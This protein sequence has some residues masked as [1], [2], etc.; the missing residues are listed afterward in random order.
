MIRSGF[1]SLLLIVI[2]FAPVVSGGEE[3]VRLSISEEALKARV[4]TLWYGI[5]FAK[6]GGGPLNQKCGYVREDFL[7]RGEGEARGWVCR[8]EGLLKIEAMGQK[9]EMKLSEEIVFGGSAPYPFREAR[10]VQSTGPNTKS[11]RIS[12]KG[13]GFEAVVD[14]GGEKQVLEIPRIDFTLADQLAGE[15]WVRQ[16][17]KPGDVLRTRDFSV[18]DLE[19][20]IDTHK[21][22]EVKPSIVAGVKMDVYVIRE[23]SQKTGD[24]GTVRADPK[25]TMLSITLGG[26]AEG[27]LEPEALAKKIEYSQDLFVFGMAKLDQPMGCEPHEV[28]Q[29][30][31]KVTGTSAGKVPTHPGQ[32]LRKEGNAFLLTLGGENV[33]PQKATEEEIAENLRE[34]PDFPIHHEQ[35]KALAQEAV[36]DAKDPNEKVHRLVAFV[37]KFVVDEHKAD[38]L[39]V[40]KI[41]KEK[42]GDCSEHALLFTTLARAAGIPAREVGGLAYMGDEFLAFGGH[43]WNEVV[44][45]G[46]WVAVDPTWGEVRADA[47]HI[48][49]STKDNA[50]FLETFGRIA[51]Q[52]V[53]VNGKGEKKE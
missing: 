10:A 52:L 30:V 32:A 27:R 45:D 4:G 15:I 37:D 12:P 28:K 43:A 2:A 42:K 46:C 13:E 29:L 20:D 19:A 23:Q 48:R 9:I 14:A 44:I 21:L 51:F 18:D 39:S 25:G 8:Y 16:K 33:A 17:P 36:G 6:E 41:I 40:F 38:I 35:V 31:L 11:V 1:L 47:T 53:S 5:Y 24:T 34:T 7:S 3:P 50:G 49:L 26:F 22:L